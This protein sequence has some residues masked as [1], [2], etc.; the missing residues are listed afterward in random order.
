MGDRVLCR[1][2]EIDMRFVEEYR[3][4]LVFRVMLLQCFLGAATFYAQTAAPNPKKEESRIPT[5]Y[6]NRALPAWIRLGGEFRARTEGRTAFGFRRGSDDGYLLTRLRL[7]FDFRLKPWFHAFVQGQDSHAPGIDPARLN[8]GLK[9]DFDLRQG[10]LNFGAWDN[11]W[12][13]LRVG[14]QEMRLGGERLAGVSDWGNVSRTFDAVYLRVGR[15]SARLNLFAASP[16]V[17]NMT[18]FDKRRPGENLYGLYGSFEKLIPRATVEPYFFWKTMPRV[19]GKDGLK[20]DADIYTIGVRWLGKLPRGFD[21]TLEMDRQVGHFA[22]SDVAAWAGYWIAGYTPPRL[23]LKPRFSVE[24]GYA[25]GDGGSGDAKF[26]TFDQLYP[27]NHGVFG[28]TDLVGWRNVR[29][30]RSGV[31]IKPHPKLALKFNYHYLG[32]ASLQD[33]F[34][35]TGGN[36]IIRAPAGGARHG[37]IGQ[38]ADLLLEYAPARDFSLGAGMGHLYPGRFLKENSPGSATSFPYLFCTYR[39]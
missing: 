29:H 3:A 11:G 1:V 35:G 30:V 34:Y 31:E 27:T 23:P 26:R 15:P 28:L 37:D 8:A 5:V 22:A 33:G 6:V 17:I 14:R 12:V 19:V 21:Y 9:N 36:L 38:E 25:T 7:S 18:R 2:N 32:L 13:G 16:V 39:F 24:Y 10:Y 4:R 20:G